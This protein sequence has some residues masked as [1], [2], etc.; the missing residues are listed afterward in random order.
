MEL[1]GS[2]Y[3]KVLCLE[4]EKTK[5][6]NLNKGLKSLLILCKIYHSHKQE[7]LKTPIRQNLLGH[8]QDHNQLKYPGDLYGP[9][10]HS[11]LH[12][13]SVS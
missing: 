12:M 8:H 10:T 11:G 13:S 6:F 9:V 2:H 5:L 7:E 1:V 4:M 3:V